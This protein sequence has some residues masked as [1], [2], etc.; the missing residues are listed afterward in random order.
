M[1]RGMLVIVPPLVY[2]FLKIHHSVAGGCPFLFVYPGED[3]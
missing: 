3:A 1:K 2:N